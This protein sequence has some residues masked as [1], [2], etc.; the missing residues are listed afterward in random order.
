MSVKQKDNGDASVSIAM[1]DFQFEFG[2]TAF[3][4]PSGS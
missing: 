2:N 3:E 1:D 4:K